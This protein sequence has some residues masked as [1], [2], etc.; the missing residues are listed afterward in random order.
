MSQFVNLLTE[1][2]NGV[3]YLTVNREDKMNALNFGTLEELKTVWTSLG[4]LIIEKEV[5]EAKELQKTKLS[6]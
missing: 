5:Q 2:K 3:L 1:E 4:N 6:K